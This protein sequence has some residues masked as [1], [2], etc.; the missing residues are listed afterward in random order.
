VKSD[1][2][3]VK[4]DTNQ[5]GSKVVVEELREYRVEFINNTASEHVVQ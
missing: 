1:T 3:K 4:S 5:V 2:N